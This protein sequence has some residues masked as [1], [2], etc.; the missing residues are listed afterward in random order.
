MP[1]LYLPREVTGNTLALAVDLVMFRVDSW[2]V[3]VMLLVFYSSCGNHQ[4]DVVFD[5]VGD[6]RFSWSEQRVVQAIADS[7]VSEIRP[8]LP[9]LPTS[10]LLRVEPGEQVNAQTGEAIAPR[11]P[12]TIYWM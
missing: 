6:Q 4:I 7:T 2:G 10:L 5:Q 11:P 8:M 3:G 9:T 12:A 1:E